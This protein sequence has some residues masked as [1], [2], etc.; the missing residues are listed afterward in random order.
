MANITPYKFVN[1]GF[2]SSKNPSTIA[3]RNSTLAIN[4]IGVTVESLANTVAG[5]SSIANLREK[6]RLKSTQLERRQERLKKD[7]EAEENEETSKLLQKKDRNADKKKLKV[8][9][10]SI[11]WLEEFIGPLG[12]I[13]LDFG[14]FALTSKLLEYLG[15]EENREKI[16]VFLDKVGFVFNKLSEFAGNI[17]QTLSDGMDAIFGK[18]S[19]IGERLNAFGKIVAAITGITGVLG[20][21]FAARDLFQ[22]SEDLAD[23]RPDG[24]NKPKK[25]R[26][27]PKPTATNPSGADPD[28]DGPR[29]RKP[30]SGIQS[31]YGDAASK[32]YKKI[33]AEY[34]DDAARAYENALRNS[35]GDAVK[36]L[37]KWRRLKLPKLAPPKPTRL[38]RAQS[39]LGNLG[40]KVQTKLVESFDWIKTGL[41]NAPEWAKNQY[42]NLSAKGRKAWETT[43]KAG[44]VIGA[45]GKQYA[46]AAGDKFKATGDWIA[47]G[48]KKFLG[49]MAQGAKNVFFEK[50]LNPLRPIIDPIAAKAKLVGDSLVSNLMK[51]PGMKKG[52]EI[53]KKKGIGSFADVATAGGKLGKRAAAVLPVIGGLV[54]L[55]FA[56]DR[57]ANGDS[58]GA[59]IEGT[60]GIL[61]IAGLFTAGSGNIASMILDG[62]M[63][64]R[65]FVPQLQDGE[66]KIVEGLG[67]SGFKSQIDSV[68][69]KLPNVGEIINMVTGNN[70]TEDV[71]ATE[72]EQQMFLG[73]VVKGIGNVV[74]GV[75][76]AVSSVVNSPIGNVVKTAASF[77]PGAAPI[78][79]GVN[80]VA[81]L[82]SGNPIQG[83][84]GAATSF[85]PGV[86]NAIGN[87]MGNS[88]I[89]SM[90]TNVMSGSYDQALSTGLSM[91]NPAIGQLAG[92][93]LKG[94]MSPMSILDSAAMQF[95][96]DGLMNSF[97]SGD[98]IGGLSETAG[99]LGIDPKVI[100]A[101]KSASKQTFSPGGLSEKLILEE[102]VEFIPLPVIIEKLQPILQAVPINTGGGA[103]SGGPSSLTTRMQ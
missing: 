34:G 19:T 89:G 67:L 17:T 7:R 29:G 26:K 91:I 80:A 81:G 59:L 79:A 13:L 84:M 77:I 39:F 93:L 28:L 62:Y 40:S 97:M 65:D 73:G 14:T 18:E 70:D 66:N 31:L 100:G 53:L 94:G 101:S 35:D 82:A 33:L 95:G 11:S 74:K 37:Q 49:N 50:V 3:A 64:I 83:L 99:A 20:A 32:Q 2:T 88:A 16:A 9:K 69:S 24:R 90:L 55:G 22:A 76:N 71:K 44:E 10:G 86:S 8:A 42:K 96:L 103:V 36:A 21:A 48:G 30:A 46:R 38:Q 57:A 6:T 25:P 27:P 102:V 15:D 60:S 98:Y 52:A 85:L 56:Y 58:I 41:M 54:N 43:V 75:G 68:L 61:D 23:A 45:K 78:M 1:P 51:I 63:F 87:F 4:R 92:S 5:L 72:P 47:D 12:K